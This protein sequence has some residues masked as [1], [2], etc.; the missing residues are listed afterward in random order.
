MSL[1]DP[2]LLP[3]AEAG[4]ASRRKRRPSVG[5][6]PADNVCDSEYLPYFDS[7]P[8]IEAESLL[9][10]AAIVSAEAMMTEGATLRV[11]SARSTPGTAT[12]VIASEACW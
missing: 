6:R 2:G 9:Y 11:A 5:M 10:S 4:G 7:S 8:D 1:S 12:L 3:D